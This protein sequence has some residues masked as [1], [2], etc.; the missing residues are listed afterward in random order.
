MRLIDQKTKQIMEDCRRVAE[1]EGLEIKGETLEFIISNED[2]IEISPK[3]MVPTLYDYWVHDVEVIRDKWVY[4]VQPHNPYETVI[5]TRPAISFYNDNNPDWV[6]A[7]I[8]YHVLGHV[9]FFHNNVFFRNT[10]DDD[11]CGVALADKRL[12]NRIR[13]DLGSEKRWVDY[14]I[15]FARGIDNLVGFYAELD[16]ADKPNLGQIFGDFTKK[17]DFYFG[18][19]LKKRYE[20]KSIELKFFYEELDRYNDCQR[21]FGA[22]GNAIF[23]EDPKLKNKFP[24]FNGIFKKLQLKGVKPKSHDILEHLIN[25]SEF[26]DKDENSWMKS[27]LD[28]VRRTSLYFQPQI[29][30][31]IGNEGWA[32]FWHERCFIRDERIKGHE[33]G[34][35]RMNSGVLMDRKLGLNPYIFGKRMFEYGEALA[36]KGKLTYAYQMLKDENARK[37]FDQ[38]CGE[39]YGKKVLFEMRRNYNDY[40]LVNFLSDDDFQGFVDQYDY[41]TAGQR[42]NQEKWVMEVYIKSRSGKEY[43]KTVN[44][45]L[46]HPP[47][48][49]I[50]SDKVKDGELYI[51]HK[52]EGRT[53][54]TPYIAP[55]LV[56]LEYLAGKKVKLETT[57]YALQQTHSWDSFDPDYKPPYKKQRVVYTCL[58][59]NVT[60]DVIEHDWKEDV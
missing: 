18:D 17:S 15:E 35:A 6:N 47:H 11:F 22:Q 5:N 26:L 46:Y 19:F 8:F 48:V 36:R 1:K 29:R 38:Q 40:M 42:L 50:D 30:D 24:E 60:R 28:V 56:G 10:W 14:V 3:L 31:K 12:I 45:S 16:E 59:K 4:G 44:D 49:V 41:F 7:F 20:E 53:L 9:D 52:Y 54:H 32:S 27:V 57:E 33:V 23:F 2:M 39:E 25:H 55:V 34:F 58:N 37:H 51:N 21:Q 13:E 43:R